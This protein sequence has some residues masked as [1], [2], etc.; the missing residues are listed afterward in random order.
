MKVE[1][2]TDV[3][4]VKYSVEIEVQRGLS[5]RK[6][7]TESEAKELRD[8]LVRALNSGNPEEEV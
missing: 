4:G 8:D 7:L 6:V 3:K 5:I 1:K 2:I